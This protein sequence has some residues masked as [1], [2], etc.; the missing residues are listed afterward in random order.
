MKKKAAPKSAKPAKEESAAAIVEELRKLGDPKIKSVLLKHGAQE[1][2]FGTRISDMKP[3]QKR[4][5]KNYELANELYATGISDAMY[6]AGLIA[7]ESQMTKTDLQKWLDAASWSMLSEFTVP[8]VAADGP[9]GWELAQKWIDKKDEKTAACGWTTL[10]NLVAVKADEELD[11]DALQTLLERVQKTIHRQPNRVR[12]AMNNFVIACGSYLRPL[13]ATAQ[14][15]AK[16]IGVVEVDMGD[17]SCQVP[18]A[19]EYIAKMHARGT[20]GKKKKTCRC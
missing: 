1:P 19:P 9:H 3:I 2:F 14:K 7:D 6:L 8:W 11:F 16:E 13:T 15:V 12:S 18:F 10:S 4:I 17:T 20:L 5:K